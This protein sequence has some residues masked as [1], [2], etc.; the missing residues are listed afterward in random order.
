MLSFSKQL[1]SYPDAVLRNMRGGRGKA[2]H[3]FREF[4]GAESQVRMEKRLKS[5]WINPRRCEKVWETI[6]VIDIQSLS[7]VSIGTVSMPHI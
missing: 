2:G 4:I 6:K 5:L 3:S 7:R 1:R